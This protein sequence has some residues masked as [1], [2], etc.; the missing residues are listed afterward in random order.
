MNFGIEDIK[1]FSDEKNYELYFFPDQL[2][3]VNY[4]NNCEINLEKINEIK[5]LI[6]GMLKGNRTCSFVN[7]KNIYGTYT[8]EAKKVAAKDPELVASKKCEVLFVNTLQIKILTQAY[9]SIFKPKSPTRVYQRFDAA[10]K[11]LFDHG[12]SATDI[13]LLKELLHEKGLIKD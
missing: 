5:S 12:T 10:S 2:V 9:I 11:M 8:D 4:F 13:L 1:R 7:L 6:L 3:F